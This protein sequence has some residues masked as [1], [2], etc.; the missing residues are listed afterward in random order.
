MP[1]FD[2]DQLAHRP[3][4]WRR[5]CRVVM[6]LTQ[7]VVVV[8]LTFLLGWIVGQMTAS[9]TEVAKPKADRSMVDAQH[10]A[11]WCGGYVTTQ[12]GGPYVVGCDR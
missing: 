8:G 2:G 12:V 11:N 10:Y 3:S 1:M 7:L 4:P 6:T 5:E 9:D